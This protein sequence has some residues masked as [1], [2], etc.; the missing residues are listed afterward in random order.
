MLGKA[1]IAAGMLLFVGL[2]VVYDPPTSSGP[3]WPYTLLKW[4]SLATLSIGGG[5]EVRRIKRRKGG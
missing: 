3:S 2:V 5:L 4:V 1:L